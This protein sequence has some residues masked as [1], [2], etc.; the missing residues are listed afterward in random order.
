MKKPKHN[1]WEFQT[2]LSRRLLLWSITSILGGLILQIPRSRFANGMGI[3]FSAWGL[4]DAIIAVFG[5]R[6]AKQRAA[7]LLDPLAKDI[8]DRESHK[9]HKIL[10]VNTG[11]DIGYMLGGSAL[12]LTKG[13]SDPGWRGHGIGIIIQGAFLFFFDLAHVLLIGQKFHK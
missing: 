9:L 12:S 4:I 13:K 6:A 3:Q 10:L 11:L 2:S 8:V 5:D 7:S 1:I